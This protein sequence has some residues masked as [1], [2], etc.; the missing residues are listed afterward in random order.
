[1]T[2]NA[3]RSL[4]TLKMLVQ[5]GIKWSGDEKFHTRLMTFFLLQKWLYNNKKNKNTNK[6]KVIDF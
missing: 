2:R 4:E 6:N 5:K 1:M 3:S